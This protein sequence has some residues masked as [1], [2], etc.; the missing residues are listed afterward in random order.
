MK[1]AVIIDIWS[2]VV[3]GSQTHVE[4]LTSSLIKNHGFKIDIFSRA[5]IDDDGKRHDDN[6][7]DCEGQRRI[8]RTVPATKTSSTWGRISTL[9]SIAW[10]VKK[11][12]K[13]E[14]YD[15][16]HAHS[17]LGGFVG[18]L[19]SFLIRRPV[20]LTVHGCPNMD[21]GRKNLDSLIERFIL[22]RIKYDKVISVG[23]SYLAH[24]NV[25]RNIEVIPNGVEIEKF[26]AL[27]DEK[28]ADFFKV[29]FV[30]RL[31]WVKG[32]DTLIESV[33]IMKEKN[34]LFLKEKILQVHIIGYGFNAERY[35]AM[36]RNSRVEDIVLFRGKI[37]GESLRREYKSSWL[38]ILPSICEGQPITILEAMAAGLP[39]LTTY[40]ADNAGIIKLETGW[41]IKEKN[42]GLLANKLAEI[43]RLD[44]KKLDE[45]GG[46]GHKN[47]SNNYTLDLVASKMVDIYSLLISNR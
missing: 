33:K 5:L 13:L 23:K 34:P 10:R 36:A 25:N 22:T 41:K 42:P 38:F 28:K 31:D 3:G 45:M 18:K 17:I 1:V 2:P 39:V 4:T 40:A 44:I 32:I 20:L 21:G 30:G 16:I 19:A 6:E 24:S 47:I 15:L 37:T 26:D 11:E 29:L 43:M 14:N 8:I 46:E 27:T 9:F 35:K 12:H 7:E